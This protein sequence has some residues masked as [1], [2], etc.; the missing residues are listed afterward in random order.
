MVYRVERGQCGGLRRHHSEQHQV[1]GLVFGAGGQGKE[2]VAVQGGVRRADAS[3]QAVVCTD[4]QALGLRFGQGGV[5]AHHTYGGV[6][7]GQGAAA[8]MATEQGVLRVE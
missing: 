4:G 8:S 1:G 7:A 2:G 3:G 5:G 6:G